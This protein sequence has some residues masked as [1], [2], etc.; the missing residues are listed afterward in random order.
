MRKIDSALV[1]D[2][3]SFVLTLL[4]EKL[5]KEYLFHSRHHTLRVA[6]GAMLIARNCGLSEEDIQVLLISAYFHD[7]GYI[8][9][10]DNHEEESLVIAAEFLKQRG[11]G[12]DLIGIVSNA[13]LATRVPQKPMDKISG[14]LCDADLM[15]LAGEDYFEQMELLRL[16]WQVTGRQFFDEYQF[17]LN[18]IEFFKHHRYHSVYGQEV[19]EPKKVL[20]LQKVRQR[21]E[22]LRQG[23]LGQDF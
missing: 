1:S 2:A 23:Q 16:E 15:H 19:M 17:H 4:D 9:C 6:R 14:I 10:D 7:T 12:E 22:T 11:V 18:S 21:I 8:V 3:E 5:S 13:I 20:C